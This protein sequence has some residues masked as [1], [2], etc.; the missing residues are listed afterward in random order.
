MINNML[1]LVFA[2]DKL[3]SRADLA[4]PVERLEEWLKAAPQ[5]PD[6]GGIH[7]LNEPERIIAHERERH[8]IPLPR[9]IREALSAC[10]RD[11]GISDM[12]FNSSVSKVQ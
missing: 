10:A 6:A 7:L 11:L 5:Q 9:R 1:S 3:V 4:R 2:T 8:G 12:D